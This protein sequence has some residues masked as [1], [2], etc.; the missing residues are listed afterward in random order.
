M[1]PRSS[2]LQADSLPVEPQGKP[3]NMRRSY[4][5]KSAALQASNIHRARTV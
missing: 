4:E 2:A 5:E 3:A 1:E